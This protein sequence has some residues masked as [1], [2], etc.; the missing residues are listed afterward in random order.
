MIGIPRIRLG[1]G[2]TT[3]PGGARGGRSRRRGIRRFHHAAATTWRAG[4]GRAGIDDRFTGELDLV[5]GDRDQVFTHTKEAADPEPHRLDVPALVHQE[6]VD[7]AELFVVV[8]V[9]GKTNDLRG[10]PFTLQL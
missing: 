7:R 1:R 9:D 4:R 8:V 2:C 10:A 5:E 6:V 3:G